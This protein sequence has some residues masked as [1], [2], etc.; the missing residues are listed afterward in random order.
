[1]N[2]FIDPDVLLKRLAERLD[3]GIRE[4]TEHIQEQ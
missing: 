2:K 1:M 4:Q 3:S